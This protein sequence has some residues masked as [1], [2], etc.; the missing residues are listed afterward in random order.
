MKN[1][2]FSILILAAGFTMRGQT[3]NQTNHAPANGD[4]YSTWQCDSLNITPGGTGAGTLW[5]FSAIVIHTAAVTNFSTVASTTSGY[6]AGC[7]ATGSST[8]DL[9]Y[10][11]S[12]AADLKY[13]GGNFKVQ[14][15]SGNLIYSTPG[16]Y[17]VYPMSLNS[18]SSATIAGSISVVNPPVSGTF[19]G[20]SIVVADGTGTLQLPGGS[21][22]TFTNVIRVVTTQTLN[23]NATVTGDI[24]LKN[25]NYYQAGIKA[26]LM[27][28]S[29]KTIVITFPPTV[30]T[31]SV[32]TINKDYMAPPVSTLS[33]N[34]PR[35]QVIEMSVYPNPSSGY[36]YFSTENQSP[37]D[38]LVYDVTG[39][40]VEKQ[41]FVN[42]KIK[43]DVSTFNNGLYI[44]SVINNNGETLKSGKVAVSH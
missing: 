22:G 27:T 29:Q 37:K 2:Y 42:G 36:V 10:T 40:L 39:K 16:I 35:K 31:E 33:V 21:A 44:Y 1:L 3:L 13:Y 4:T 23:Y 26:P 18:T 7:Q 24:I 5:N 34:D 8:N 9:V 14:S 15:Y 38:V 17:G 25:Y 43:L 41:S 30:L 32:I 28:I 11:A 12:T 6:P 19:S 20:N